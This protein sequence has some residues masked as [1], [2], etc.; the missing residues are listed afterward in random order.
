MKRFISICMTL[1][2]VLAACTPAAAP[3]PTSPTSH[4]CTR[5]ANTASRRTQ[6]GRLYP[7][8]RGFSASAADIWVAVRQRDAGIQTG[9]QGES[10]LHAAH[11]EPLLQRHR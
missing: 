4:F 9:Q 2:F 7:A 1:V 11:D 10:C 8:R 6:C 5:S 3:T